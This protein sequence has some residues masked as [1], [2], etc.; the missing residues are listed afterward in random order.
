MRAWRS[1]GVDSCSAVITDTHWTPLPRPPSTENAHAIQSS[2]A[3]A[4]PR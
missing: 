4:M 3:T 1:S 2:R